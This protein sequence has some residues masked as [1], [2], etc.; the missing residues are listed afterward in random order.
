MWVKRFK[1]L[2]GFS[3]ELQEKIILDLMNDIWTLLFMGQIALC[4]TGN[5]YLIKLR[6]FSMKKKLLSLTNRF[7]K[8]S[9]DSFDFAHNSFPFYLIGHFQ[10]RFT[11][12]SLP[13]NHLICYDINVSLSFSS[14]PSLQICLFSFNTYSGL[15]SVLKET[16]GRT[17]SK[18]YVCADPDGITFNSYLKRLMRI[19]MKKLLQ[20]YLRRV[21]LV[22]FFFRALHQYRLCILSFELTQQLTHM[23]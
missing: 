14:V 10:T 9:I 16:K 22:L 15:P 11:K 23:T 19:I 7:L 21:E 18:F 12:V 4:S 8:E 1:P 17:F 6:Y 5:Y 20:R 3:G 13:I 2:F